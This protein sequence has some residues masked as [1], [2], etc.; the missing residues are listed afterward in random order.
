MMAHERAV[1]VHLKSKLCMERNTTGEAMESHFMEKRTIEH[2]K[3]ELS[4]IYLNLGLI[5][6][7]AN[8]LLK[9]IKALDI[10]EDKDD[11][12][13]LTS[14]TYRNPNSIVLN[15]DQSIVRRGWLHVRHTL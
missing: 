14:S 6:G 8:D 1:R 2:G 5:A 12:A 9:V 11:Q 4:D 10:Q 15:Y 7:K 13:V 3:E